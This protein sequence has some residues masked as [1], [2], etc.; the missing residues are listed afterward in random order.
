MS[1]ENILPAAKLSN[2]DIIIITSRNSLRTLSHLNN[3]TKKH[4]LII[5]GKSTYLLAQEKGF[6]TCKYAGK[7]LEELCKYIK[8]HY[9][10]RELVYLSGEIVTEELN[11]KNCN[12][13][14]NRIIVYKTA[15]ADN[16]S[17]NFKENILKNNFSGVIFFSKESA[18]IF[19]ELLKKEGLQPYLGNLYAFCLSPEISKSLSSYGFKATMYAKNPYMNAII[20]MI[21]NFRF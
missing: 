2:D 13:Y 15:P 9:K 14:I 18:R 4:E 1:I 16:L 5:L 12:A 7:N 17:I 10:D 3:N 20:K 8:S 6:S 19:C 11:Y 21:V